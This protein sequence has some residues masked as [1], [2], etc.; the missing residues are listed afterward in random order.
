MLP[1]FP[2]HRFNPQ[3]IK[4]DVV[5]TMIDGGTANTGSNAGHDFII[6]A[7]SDTGT[8]LGDAVVITRADR[9]ITLGGGYS[10]RHR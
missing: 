6:R 9:T 7:L 1:I 2:T 3:N 4:A 8:S 5:P 10:S